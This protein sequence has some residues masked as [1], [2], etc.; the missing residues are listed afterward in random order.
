MNKE[1]PTKDSFVDLIASTWDD[2]YGEKDTDAVDFYLKQF[3]A[4]RPLTGSTLDVGCGTGRFLIPLLEKGY[5]G[6]GLDQSEEMLAILHKKAEAINK[7]AETSNATIQDFAGPGNFDGIVAFFLIFYLH[8]KGELADFFAKA[9]SLLA[10]G[11]VLFFNTYNPIALWQLSQWKFTE[12]YKFGDGAGRVEYTFTPEDYLRAKANMEDYRL[13]SK[14]GACNFAYESRKVRFYT[15]T[16]LS[17]ML[18]KAGFTDIAHHTS[19]Y[20]TPVTED[21]TQGYVLFTV[22]R[23]S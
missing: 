15:M 10:P 7:T 16:E 3:S 17:L 9:H 4:E 23:K 2:C 21:T 12:T 22:A 13:I 20:G 19:L 18:E 14:A 5:N 8:Q 1:K 6:I 11:G